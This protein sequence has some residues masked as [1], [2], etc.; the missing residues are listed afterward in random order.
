MLHDWSDEECVKILRRCRNAIPSQG[1]VII[2]ESVFG[3]SPSRVMHQAQ[4]LL[5]LGM[6]VLTKG[7]EREE[8]EWHKMFVDAGFSHY[9]VKPV[10]G[11]L[12]I[13][14]VYP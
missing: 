14:E 10:L 6:M 9:K 4:L 3:S 5:D 12:S 2:V 7:K 1:K 8:H 11:V 13:I